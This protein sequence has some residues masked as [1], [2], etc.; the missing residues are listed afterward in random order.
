MLASTVSVGL[1]AESIA[2]GAPLN[3]RGA[4]R[5]HGSLRR[6]KGA[7]IRRQSE[8]KGAETI[9][10]LPLLVDTE[11]SRC[12]LVG[13]FR[14]C[15][16]W[17]CIVL[18]GVLAV[19]MSPCFEHSVAYAQGHLSCD[20]DDRDS[21]GRRDGSRSGSASSSNN[22]GSTDSLNPASCWEQRPIE[23]LESL[24]NGTLG[25]PLPA[26]LVC[27]ELVTTVSEA[28][29]ILRRSRS[30]PCSDFRREALA[31]LLN[32]RRSRLSGDGRFGLDGA[33]C[34]GVDDFR[35]V[36][37]CGSLAVGV[38][39][40][41]DP[42]HSAVLTQRTPVLE[43]VEL[44]GALCAI[45]DCPQDDDFTCGRTISRLA[46]I[47]RRVND[48]SSGGDCRHCREDETA[49]TLTCPTGHLVFERQGPHGAVIS[50]G[51]SATDNCDPNPHVVCFPPPGTVLPVG[52][53]RTV[54]C[55]A[56]D[57]RG[58]RSCCEF[59]VEVTDT[60]PPTIV[61][62]AGPIVVGCTTGDGSAVVHYPSPTAQDLDGQPPHIVC[63]PSSG[64]VFGLGE[65]TVVCRAEDTSGNVS[66]CSFSV[67]VTEDAP[68]RLFCPGDMVVTCTSSEGATVDFPAPTI[69]TTCG[70]VEDKNCV[71]PSGS[72]F[73]IGSTEV[74]C[75]ATT[76]DGE[77]LE[78]RFTVTVADSS[79]P[80][81]VCPAPIVV[82][83]TSPDGTPVQF[84]VTA[85]DDCDPEPVVTTTPASGHL[86]PP[87]ETSVVCTAT[88]VSGNTT[89]CE[90]IVR[91]IDT[92]APSITCSRGPIRVA[93]S[94]TEPKG[95]GAPVTYPSPMV[96]DN[97]DSDVTVVCDPPSGSVFPL[98]LTLVT[99][100]A[101]DDSG[102]SAEC[103]FVVD[104]DDTAPPS[105]SCVE[106]VTV[107]CTGP[108]GAVVE[109]PEPVASNEC[110]GDPTITCEPESGSLF[111]VGDTSVVC[112][113]VDQSGNAQQCEFTVSVTDS[114]PPTLACPSDRIVECES[115]EGSVVDF[116]VTAVDRCDPSPVVSCTPPSGSVF[117]PGVT[118]VECLAVD[119]W[120]NRSFCS[121]TVSVVD[122][123]P[124]VL[125][126]PPS[127]T[128]ECQ[129]SEGT[130]VTFAPNVTDN[131]DSD[132]DVLCVPASGELFPLGMTAVICIATDDAGLQSA[133]RFVV[134]VVDTTPPSLACSEDAVVVE[135]DRPG[136]GTIN[137]PAPVAGDLC[138]SS[139][140]IVCD[141]VVG[142]V[143]PLGDHVV[144]CV[145]T[146]ESG[147]SASCEFWVSVVD[148]TPP[149][150][151]CL[152]DITRECR[153]PEGTI[154]EYSSPVATDTCDVAPNLTCLPPSGSVFPPGDTVVTCTADDQSGNMIQCSFTVHIT[155]TLA[156]VILCPAEVVASCSS[157]F[158]ATVVFGV[159]AVDLC[160][161]LP[162]VACD[163][164]L[165]S[166]FPIGTTTVTCTATDRSGNVSTCALMVTV[167]DDRAPEI[168]C[169]QSFERGCHGV[170]GAI[171]EYPAPSVFDE[172]DPDPVVVCDPPSG[173]LLSMG[174]H[175][176]H[177]VASDAS[178]N[179]SVCQFVGTVVGTTVPDLIC[180]PDV[181][182]QCTTPDGAVVEYPTPV[183]NDACDE[184]PAVVCVPPSGSVFPLGDTEVVC[185]STDAS[186][187]TTR[188]SFLVK[189]VD[190]YGP[191]IECPRP[192]VVECDSYVGTAVEFDVSA[193]DLCDGVVNVV[194]DPPSGALFP[195]GHTTVVCRSADAEGNVS[196]CAF[197]VSVL[198]RT[199][200]DITCTTDVVQVAC[201]SAGQRWS[202]L[203]GGAAG[204]GGESRPCT[205]TI[206]YDEATAVD[207]CQ[208]PDIP[209]Y[210]DCSP[211]QG[212][213]LALG[214]HEVT[215]RSR[216][217]WGNESHC[218]FTVEI[219]RG[220]GSFVRG[221]TNGDAR[222]D[223][224]DAVWT[225]RYLFLGGPA[226]GCLD[227]SDVNDDGRLDL[228]DGIYV[229]DYQFRGGARPAPPNAPTCGL[230]TT[231]DDALDCVSYPPCE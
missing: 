55:V 213:R 41:P 38:D 36:L 65:T 117:P 31:T 96:S 73:P 150:L 104:V 200:P 19:K 199:A 120:G 164:P 154:V 214:S 205:T 81:L 180:P 82:E 46:E 162:Q 15:A 2:C 203:P 23:E 218:T 58:N 231:Q 84:E 116:V 109:Y 163:P 54:R 169:P 149:D 13:L 26:L 42:E 156:P 100:T 78:C 158:G 50:F 182:A 1:A 72:L 207:S 220:Q 173:T 181:T 32:V 193:T 87:G 160:D 183:A 230:D 170:D 49:P 224:A 24:L 219:V 30:T 21:R 94:L 39:G 115:S 215:C 63:E 74:V 62:P 204:A 191:E 176:V 93:C 189:V 98:G 190:T 75:T 133:A 184:A 227:S 86:F 137:Y 221:D 8:G 186:G 9:M 216:D 27:G 7:R 107:E 195:I 99:C 159:N 217:I 20:D 202:F 59:D 4:L 223:I 208:P 76:S 102:N 192:I 5:D 146:D 92:T 126:S 161:P 166:R 148:T 147:N 179:V 129:G 34:Y 43:L 29:S 174:A 153:G 48:S 6:V 171:V 105:L 229:L 12:S 91:I 132:V 209:I 168:L 185:S 122:T 103:F 118:V 3:K 211:P 187:N 68:Q 10:S 61:C 140:T 22:C 69:S 127:V 112:N 144:T 40:E 155:D 201:T 95:G 108:D 151:V 130:I 197:V 175:T 135:C 80:T 111:P 131:C 114:T 83:C 66:T 210:I 18:I 124:P 172:C 90:F 178:G 47:L 45:A 212:T 101:T 188:C 97:C 35:I 85:R 56:R 226:P 222:I 123:T 125:A 37:R 53:R 225:F 64:S 145:A 71:P 206:V 14:L 28:R 44:G 70:Q 143:L 139:P 17:L 106:S 136:A 141:P 25:E 51:V 177:C 67:V 152:E 119:S 79:P 142:T 228:A 77:V 89:E 88:D 16:R 128:V 121:F 134:E 198:D 194:S 138:D 60:T 196:V 52:L 110:D 33:R 167:L 11:R 113:A 57:L 165:G 157:P